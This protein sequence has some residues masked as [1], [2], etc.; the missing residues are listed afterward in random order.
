MLHDYQIHAESE[1]RSPSGFGKIY[2]TS[3]P[4][5]VS[6]LQQLTASGQWARAWIE[7]KGKSYTVENLG[8]MP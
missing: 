2:T 6:F 5:A 4:R 8:E 3:R 7:F 1:D